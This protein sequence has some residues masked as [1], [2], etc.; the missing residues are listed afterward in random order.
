MRTSII[1][2]F[3]SL[4]AISLFAGKASADASYNL[5]S[6]SLSA[7]YITDGLYNRWWD[8]GGSTVVEVNKY[9]RL[10]SN[11]NS[12]Q[13]WLW[14]RAPLTAQNWEV[15]F[16]FKVGEINGKDH[17]FGDGFAFFY[18]VDRANL[19][20]VF[21]SKDYFNGL[22]V[23]FDTYPNS[24][25]KFSFPRVMPMIGDGKT[26]YDNDHDGD[27]NNMNLGCSADFRD[28]KFP[29]KAVVRY[30]K[31]E[32]VEVLLKIKNDDI[33]QPCFSIQNVTLPTIGYIGFTSHTGDAYDIHDIISVDTKGF[34]IPS[35]RAKKTHG[36]P[37]G[38]VKQGIHSEYNNQEGTGFGF[39]FWLLCISGVLG[40]GYVVYTK[41]FKDNGR[42]D[43]AKLF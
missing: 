23:F 40:I 39:L 31:G 36:P 41:K 20:P 16:E 30:K 28:K 33:W 21:G 26:S 11:Q 7:P 2:S 6:H 38:K 4:S 22:G 12:Q 10:T 17:L 9:V 25:H 15:E 34:I 27:A 13:G 19:G 14:S 5:K 32:Y 18:T 29:T 42:K 1:K 3:L 24:R 35:R 37:E 8:F 43:N